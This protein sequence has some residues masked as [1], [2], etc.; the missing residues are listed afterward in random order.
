MDLVSQ[1][2]IGRLDTMACLDATSTVGWGGDTSLGAL[3]TTLLF[4]SCLIMSLMA[5]ATQI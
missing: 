2:C 5:V 1:I 3:I 4:S